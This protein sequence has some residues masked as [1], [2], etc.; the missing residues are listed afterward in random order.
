MTRVRIPVLILTLAA[1][2]G[3]ALVG[4][5]AP[6]ATGGKMTASAHA[7]LASLTPEFKT[8]AR[9]D[10]N[11]KHRTAWFF[12]PQQDKEKKFTRKGARLEEMTADQKKAALALL[13]SGLSAK[14]YEQATTIMDLENLLLELEGPKGAMT[15]N[16]NWYFVSIFGE[17]SSTGKWGWRFEGHHLSVNYTIDK[18]EVVAGA[19]I[20]FASNP[21]EVKDGTK[22]GLR[23]LPEIE[24]HARA[25]ITSLKDDQ[26]KLAKQ[27]KAFPEINEG[28]PRADVGAPVGIT[29]DK[30]TAEQKATLM[31]LVKAYADRMPEEFAAAEI[32][33]VTDTPD[34]KLYFAYSGGPKP[35]EPYTYRVQGPE[36]VVEFLNVQADS[37]KNPA[38]HI[39]SAWRRLPID[40][41]LAE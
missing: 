30:L 25:L 22:K 21:A 31:K 5:S 32:K 27:P 13:R 41:G 39:H 16:T 24:D 8:K 29:A 10:F 28:K 26:N 36:F 17:P 15:R 19:P 6:E 37:A 11:D 33:K 38:N 14:G 2:A 40:F 9:F 23:P 20:L 3:V 7:F 12:T 18:G 35:G 34:E 1:V 4:T